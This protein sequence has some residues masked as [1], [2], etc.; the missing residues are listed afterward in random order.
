MPFNLDQFIAAYRQVTAQFGYAP[1]IRPGKIELLDWDLE[2]VCGPALA[3]FIDQILVRQLNDFIPDNDHPLILDCGANIGFTVLNYKRQFPRARIIAFEPDPQ[4]APVLRR[5]LEQNGAGDVQVV[6]A[7]A[8]IRDGQ[9]R[10]LC[11]GIDGSR[12]VDAEQETSGIVSVRTVDLANYLTEAVDLLK[13]DIEGAEY[14]VV[15][16]LGN[17]LQ[18]VKN[19]LV[20]CHLDQTKIVPFGNLLCVL[21]DAGFNMSVNSFGDWR[22][23][24]RQTPVLPPH[25]EQYLLVT[26]W[27][28]SIPLAS[29]ERSLLPYTGVQP[30]IALREARAESQELRNALSSEQSELQSRQVELAARER[31]WLESLRAYMV[32]GRGLLNRRVL[33]VPFMRAGEHG[34]VVALPD[35]RHDADN[36]Q[37]PTR[38]TLVLFENDNLLG[39]AHSL[40]DD[41]RK[42]G[43]GRYSHWTN[44]LY[45]STPDNSDPNTNGRKYSIVFVDQKHQKESQ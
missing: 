45:I 9:A 16:H 43:G 6:E 15:A 42:L 28:G 13:M 11:E 17:R 18:N 23:L 5:N 1:V 30:E 29:Q 40:H 26:G 37:N 33:T 12:I 27:H 20:E 19:I 39:P 7:A 24:I 3:T 25:W 14:E 34:W 8:W 44:A 21:A 2:Y 4:F 32:T 22:D 36:Q 31:Q 35:L 10:W 38:S 41:I